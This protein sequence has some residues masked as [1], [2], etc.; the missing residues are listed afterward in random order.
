MVD[1]LIVTFI[2]EEH[3]AVWR[4]FRDAADGAV[5][6]VP[7][8]TRVVQVT[9]RSGKVRVAIARTASEGNLSAQDAVVELIDEQKPRLVLAVGIAGAVPTSDVFL[10]DVVLAKDI[11]DLTCGAETAAG[12]EEAVASLY[13]MNAVKDFVANLTMDDFKEWQERAASIPRP[14]VKGIGSLWT[15]DKQWDK[16]INESLEDNERRPLPKV[17]DGVI[18]SSDHLVKSK[19]FMKRRLLVDRRIL[20]NDME[21]AGV[22]KACERKMVPLLILRGISDIVGHARSEDWKR[23]ACEVV[24]GCAR[25]VVNLESVDTIKSR[26]R[27][28]QPGLS[29]GTKDVI[30]S[31]DATLAPIQRG[32]VSES[33]SACRD[34]FDL[35]KELPDELKRRWA[36][37]LFNTLDRPM[38]YLGDKKLV[39][40]VA[41]ACIE[42]CSGVDLDDTTAE[43]QARAR[44][45][46]TSWAYQRTGNL[47][48]AEQEAQESV[49]I[50]KG[51]GS[52]KNLAFC[53]KCLGR[54]KR[55]RAEAETR[56]EVRRARF[57]DSMQ[58]LREAI[59]LFS[60][61]GGHGPDGSEVGDCYSLLGRTYLSAEDVGMARDCAGEALS[62]ID[63]C[64]KDYLDL[65]IL[66]GDIWSAT[67]EDAKALE[68]FEE[69]INL[70]S[71]QDYQI[72][73]IVA[74]AH[75]QKAATLMRMGQNT[76]AQTAFAEAQRIWEHYEEENF[77]AEAEWGGI[78]ASGLLERERRTIR[79]LEEEEPMVRCLAVKLYRE[80]QSSRSRRVVAQRIGADDRVWK[81]LVK[82]AKRLLALHSGSD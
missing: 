15:D 10:G 58:R 60:D 4:H 35:F 80:G 2:P 78:R 70:A 64:S 8:A 75:R 51:I 39:L 72:S 29:D 43:C 49:R 47:G 57:E 40:E 32:D 20:A 41:N 68:A 67:G 71:E 73:E 22:A 53:M 50:S 18:A 56:S 7:G 6:G 16:K 42:C 46:G 61:L 81:N 11:R 14:A 36:P 1:Y 17:V 13:L 31:L 55:L 27:S 33:A 63:D 74:R 5:S 77:A 45:C 62:R 25:E 3:E 76:D 52:H 69:V 34:A 12:R 37:E 9:T 38:K 48:L 26:Q 24:A 19:S 65:R 23:Y 28:E 54:L 82:K 30:K 59:S 66:E 21:S 79:L 44:I